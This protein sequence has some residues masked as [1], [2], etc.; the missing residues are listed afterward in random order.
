MKRSAMGENIQ[1]A[2]VNSPNNHG[3]EVPY[4]PLHWL[5]ICSILSTSELAFE[6]IFRL[7]NL[8]RQFKGISSLRSKKP[9]CISA[10]MDLATA[11]AS[12]SPGQPFPER[13][14]S[15][16]YSQ[17]AKESHT[18]SV[19]W[20]RTGTLSVGEYGF[21][22]FSVVFCHKGIRISE[23]GIPKYFNKSHGLSDHDE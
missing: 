2:I 13:K 11:R 8:L 7:S 23:K 9:E 6:E 1:S 10:L 5:H 15:E 21:N 19:A 17:I 16:M 18:V 4:F 12:V 3:P 22:A 14:F 20:I